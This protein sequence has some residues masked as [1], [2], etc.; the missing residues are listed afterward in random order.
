MWYNRS[1][2]TSAGGRKSRHPSLFCSNKHE[3]R[4]VSERRVLADLRL[5]FEHIRDHADALDDEDHTAIEAE[6]LAQR[7][8]EAT[9]EIERLR[10]NLERIDHQHYVVSPNERGWIDQARYE[11]LTADIQEKII[12]L[13]AE[14][15][16]LQDEVQRVEDDGR[17]A[18]RVEA[19]RD[20]GLYWL[21]SD[22]M[23]GANAFLRSHVKVYVRDGRVERVAVI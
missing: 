15:E 5:F 23:Q 17:R 6:T 14:I 7:T 19:V 21:E 2:Y 1:L 13:Q 18:E 11:M 20:A 4:F 10:G 9:A 3:H 12:K 8:A 16:R 22:D